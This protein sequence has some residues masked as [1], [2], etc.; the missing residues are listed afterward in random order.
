MKSETAELMRRV[1]ERRPLVHQITNYVTVN[2]CANITLCAGG[3]PVMS[4]APEEVSEM[5]RHASALVL[6]IGTLVDETLNSMIMAGKAANER[7]IPVILDPVG[8]GATG[9]R[10]DAVRKILDNVR[11]SVLKGNAGE[12]G[13]LAGAGGKVR[14]VDSGGLDGDPAE[15]CRSLSERIGAVVVMTG[16]VDVIAD[17]KR[18]AVVNNGHAMMSSVSGT[19]C[20]AGA[21]I[22]CYAGC[23]D[24]MLMASA[25]A[26]AVFCIAGNKAAKRSKGPGTFIANLMDDMANLT[27]NEVIPLAN[28]RLL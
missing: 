4:E 14:G 18:T 23:T 22:G 27:P 6:N 1:R 16:A 12:I 15:V 2:D 5:V 9:Y 24:D 25:A 20:M 26:L 19:G 13:A 3:S 10:T 17:G 28:I 11:I 7:G 8:A 21:V